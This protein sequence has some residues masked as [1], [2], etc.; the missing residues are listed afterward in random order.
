MTVL[1]KMIAMVEGKK[2]HTDCICIPLVFGYA[3]IFQ[4]VW[5]K[6][7]LDNGEIMADCQLRAQKHFGYDA[8]F[9]YGDNSLEAEV[10]GC[11]TYFPE[12]DYPYVTRPVF[13][14][15][16]KIKDLP[17]FDP[18]TAGRMREVI[19]ACAILKENVKDDI[20][21]VG[22]VVGPTSI[23][24]QLMGLDQ[25]LYLLVDEPD[26][27]RSLL[28]QTFHVCK[29]Y[30]KALIRSGASIIII[31]EPTASQNI[32]PPR[33]FRKFVAPLLKE[34][35]SHFRLEGAKINWL[36]IT[37]RTKYIIPYYKD[38]GVDLATIDYEVSLKECMDLAPDL[39]LAGN[40][41]PFDLINLKTE[42]IAKQCKDLL[43]IGS[44]GKGFILSTGCEVPLNANP[45]NISI[46][47]KVVKG[48]VFA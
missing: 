43:D 20:P 30:G 8:V 14:S 35:F 29:D 39:A 32:I 15:L 6:D 22:C 5:L 2:K 25:L 31:M 37:G 12:N 19:K 44:K 41:K 7:Y 48:E 27:F 24:G 17:L 16:S 45:A 26:K 47:G 28:R 9:A 1:Q 18:Y 13:S 10:L 40:I 21:V 42:D 36:M 38:C 4:G 33:I 34:L 46:M 3:A 23:A 11:K